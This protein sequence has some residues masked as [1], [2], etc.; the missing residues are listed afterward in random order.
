MNGSFGDVLRD[1]NYSCIILFTDALGPVKFMINSKTSS[2]APFAQ[3]FLSKTAKRNLK[4]QQKMLLL[5]KQS[6]ISVGTDKSIGNSDQNATVN[7]NDS[8]TT[9]V[10]PDTDVIANDNNKST[11]SVTYAPLQK[12]KYGLPL[13]Q[14]NFDTRTSTS[15]SSLSS[16]LSSPQT[17]HLNDFPL[18]PL[19]DISTPPP[20]IIESKCESV[21]TTTNTSTYSKSPLL[22][23]PF[24]RS[25]AKVNFSFNSVKANNII[26]T[27][28]A[29][30]S[31]NSAGG[32]N[33]K[34]KLRNKVPPVKPKPYLID[35]WPQSLT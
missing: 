29:A 3:P 11:P 28:N 10:S 14:S 9:I 27:T 23:L 26:S 13:K 5:K 30:A 21:P 34:N 12:F 35:D 4:K 16:S 2:A 17:S 20:R 25:A 24:P 1:N 7:N 32:Y 22:P 19:P 6:E 18:P 8:S 31:S 15:S 33:A